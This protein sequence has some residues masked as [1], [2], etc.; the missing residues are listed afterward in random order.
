MAQLLQLKPAWAGHPTMYQDP[1]QERYWR[2]FVPR[3]E[4]CSEENK[5]R[6]E[7]RRFTDFLPLCSEMGENRVNILAFEYNGQENRGVTHYDYRDYTSRG[8]V[9]APLAKEISGCLENTC[10]TDPAHSLNTL[11]NTPTQFNPSTLHPSPSILPSAGIAQLSTPHSSS[12][13][14]SSEAPFV[15][16]EL[17]PPHPKPHPYHPLALHSLGRNPAASSSRFPRDDS[18][19]SL[20]SLE[21]REV[22]IRVVKPKLTLSP[23]QKPKDKDS[24][25]DVT[26]R[27][28]SNQVGQSQ[29]DTMYGNKQLG[30]KGQNSAEGSRSRSK[31]TDKYSRSHSR[32]Q[33]QHKQSFDTQEGYSRSRDHSTSQSVSNPD[34]S[35][36]DAS[37]RSKSPD[38]GRTK[39]RRYEFIDSDDKTYTELSPILEV[40]KKSYDN[41]GCTDNTGRE[42]DMTTMTDLIE[43]CTESS[44]AQLPDHQNRPQQQSNDG[45]GTSA[46]QP[47]LP[48][49]KVKRRPPPLDLDEPIRVGVV[50]HDHFQIEHVAIKSS[51]A[52]HFGFSGPKIDLSKYD[53]RLKNPPK[54]DPVIIPDVKNLYEI[55]PLELYNVWR[56]NLKPLRSPSQGS[57]H[58]RVPGRERKNI[59]E[60][61]L[62]IADYPDAQST[63]IVNRVRSRSTLGIREDRQFSGSSLYTDSEYTPAMPSAQG[64]GIIRSATMNDAM[65]RGRQFSTGSGSRASY[66]GAMEAEM[67]SPPFTPL[68]P[69]IMKATGAPEGAGAGAKT[70]FGENGWLEDTA[71]SGTKKPKTEK[72][73]GFL[74]SLKRKAREIADSTSFKPARNARATAVN[75]M[76]IS[77]DAR[78]QSLLYC[79]LEYNLNNA[80]DAYF[81][82]Q[83]NGGRLD[84]TKLSRIADAW[85]QKGRPKVIGFRYDLETQVDL[86][87]AHINEFRFYGLLQAEGPAAITGLLQ[88]MK[89][90]ARYMRIRTFCQPDSV[91]AKHV[92]DAQNFLLLLG[93]PEA[94]QRPLEEVAQFFKVAVQ[95][96]RVMAEAPPPRQGDTR[97]LS[98]GSGQRVRFEDEG[99]QRRRHYANMPEA[100][101]SH[102][103]VRG[104]NYGGSKPQSVRSQN[105]IRG[106]NQ[107]RDF[108]GDTAGT[109][110]V[111]GTPRGRSRSG[112]HQ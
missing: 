63:P 93:S 20:S 88:A 100:G 43:K 28:I 97:I 65:H 19:S 106:Q 12:I 36:S 21:A 90:N 51:K 80:L 110:K 75:R 52:E 44:P 81:R 107:Q 109:T 96:H 48:Q 32:S 31:A 103:D 1:S 50:K 84:A 47:F 69:F 24:D 72:V 101:K 33:S 60:D 78:E 25:E 57:V 71:A 54:M 46:A 42:S 23:P 26:D 9:S 62:P 79:E 87:M 3:S 6:L 49:P 10:P 95:R 59:D 104:Q 85:S 89:T 102:A 108:S 64:S 16:T 7:N 68:T 83:L 112:H 53:D 38:R 55:D 29:P 56:Q 76:N 13:N 77:L 17:I 27:A 37:T 11:P 98:N 86:I 111:Y 41:G 105:G 30:Q 4:I 45:V 99:S 66:N 15:M 14:P 39:Q 2:S 5:R 73:G 61:H 70:L 35:I 34:P 8:R 67:T 91:I 74:E 82:A 94:L 40:A 22:S 58:I 92:L 18:G